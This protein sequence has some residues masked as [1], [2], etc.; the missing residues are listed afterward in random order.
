MI[1]GKYSFIQITIGSYE[2]SRSIEARSLKS[3]LNHST[4]SILFDRTEYMDDI[5]YQIRSHSTFSS[6]VKLSSLFFFCDQFLASF[7]TS[8]A[9]LRYRIENMYIIFS[10]KYFQVR[11]SI[12][13]I[14]SNKKYKI[15]VWSSN[16]WNYNAWKYNVWKILRRHT[17]TFLVVILRFFSFLTSPV[18]SVNASE[19]FTRGLM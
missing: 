1:D 7:Q 17:Y 19:N 14:A 5:L 15:N 8:C 2:N 11:K 12:L 16:I 6:I 13:T 9:A 10:Y 4:R 3:A 18:S